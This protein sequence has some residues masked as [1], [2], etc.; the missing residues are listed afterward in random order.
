MLHRAD[1]VE[2]V[3]PSVVVLNRGEDI[4]REHSHPNERMIFSRS[5]GTPA[6]QDRNCIGI[7]LK[8]VVLFVSDD[9]SPRLSDPAQITS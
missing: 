3:R 5:K 8:L 1:A 2:D 6:L 7:K 9:V 4:T